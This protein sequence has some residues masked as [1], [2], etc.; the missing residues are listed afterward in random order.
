MG[1][2]GTLLHTW[3]ILINSPETISPIKFRMPIK[4]ALCLPL[5]NITLLH[6]LTLHLKY[7]LF[8]AFRNIRHTPIMATSSH[9]TMLLWPRQS[10]DIYHSFHHFSIIA[11]ITSIIISTSKATPFF[12][13]LS[14]WRLFWNEIERYGWQDSSKYDFLSPLALAR[15]EG[16]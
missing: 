8:V 16:S 5:T 9:I 7:H 11:Y 15:Q 10:H 3:V 1:L 13:F 2:V 4:A 14:R 6:R 12:S